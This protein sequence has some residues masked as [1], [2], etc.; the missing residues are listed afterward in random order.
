MRLDSPTH[1]LR[2]LLRHPPL[3]PSAP[4]TTQSFVPYIYPHSDL[5]SLL[6]A[7]PRC[8]RASAC[9]MSG[10]TFRTLLLFLY[11]TGPIGVNYSFLWTATV[12]PHRIDSPKLLLRGE[13]LPH[14][15]CY[16]REP[17]PRGENEETDQIDHTTR[18]NSSH[19]TGLSSSGSSRQEVD[20]R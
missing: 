9:V 3:P 20:P 1:K 17:T 11:G 2:W 5:R 8:Q 12:S 19:Q 16:R 7:V 13:W 18:A 15:K 4:K 6:S 14:S 10:A